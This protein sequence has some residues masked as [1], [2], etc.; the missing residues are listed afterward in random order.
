MPSDRI[1]KIFLAAITI[2]LATLAI[3]MVSREPVQAQ[4]PSS[5]TGEKTYDVRQVRAI[6]IP[7]IKEVTPLESKGDQRGTDFVVRT[8][9]GIIVYRCDYY[10]NNQ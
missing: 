3:Q 7:E 8:N 9:D 10:Y 2:L 6:R 1:V 5:N 4:G